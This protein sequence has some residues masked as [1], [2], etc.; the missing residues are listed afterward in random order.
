MI[1]ACYSYM[2][3]IYPA[4]EDPILSHIIEYSNT[5]PYANTQVHISQTILIRLFGQLH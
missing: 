3:E 5:R 1:K 2:L 4:S